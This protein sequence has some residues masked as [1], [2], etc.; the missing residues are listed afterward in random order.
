VPVRDLEYV[1]TVRLDRSLN[2]VTAVV[3]TFEDERETYRTEP[4]VGPFDTWEETFAAM[5]ESLDRQLE[6]WQAGR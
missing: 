5:G 4:L 6:I 2:V 1:L 3:T